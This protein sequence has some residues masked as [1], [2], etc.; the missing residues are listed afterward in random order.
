MADLSAKLPCMPYNSSGAELPIN[1]H[2][3]HKSSY[4]DSASK[5][6]C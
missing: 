3:P 6:A 1:F 5:Y 2:G 4:S